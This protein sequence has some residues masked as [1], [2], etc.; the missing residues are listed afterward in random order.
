MPI[1]SIT[2][3]DRI[4]LAEKNL[5]REIKLFDEATNPNYVVVDPDGKVLGKLGGRL[6]VA[7]RGRSSAFLEGQ[8]AAAKD[9][10]G[11]RAKVAAGR[12][13]RSIDELSPRAGPPTRPSGRRRPPRR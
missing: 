9:I 7:A 4:E 10:E 13:D 6:Q 3:D 11:G 12:R 2:Q 5:D 8:A 1:K